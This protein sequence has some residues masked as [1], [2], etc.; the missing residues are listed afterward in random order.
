VLWLTLSA[1]TSMTIAPAPALAQQPQPFVD[2]AGSVHAESI[3]ALA[4]WGITK[5]CN[6]AGTLFC[7]EDPVTR[8]Q[9]ASFLARSFVTPDSEFDYFGDDSGNTH[10]VSINSIASV[11]ITTG[12]GSGSSY[13]PDSSVTRG[14]MAAFLARTLDLPPGPD[15][16]GDDG[17]STFQDEI[18]SLAGAGITQGCSDTSFCP[19]EPVTRGQMASFLVRAL[20]WL[21]CT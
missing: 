3:V 15:R 12:C 17:T 16:F 13:C 11:G 10:E 2:I 19:D 5:G 14:Q 1:I 21:G 9:M 18:N 7:P 6:D 8:A 4:Q 20:E